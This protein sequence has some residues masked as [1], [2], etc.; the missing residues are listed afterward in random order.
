MSQARAPRQ[1]SEQHQ[2]LDAA[3]QHPKAPQPLLE[4]HHQL[5]ELLVGLQAANG[6]VAE[7]VGHRRQWERASHGRARGPQQHM[8]PALARAALALKSGQ[9]RNREAPASAGYAVPLQAASAAESSPATADLSTG[10]HAKPW[11]GARKCAH[12]HHRCSPPAKG[13]AKNKKMQRSRRKMQT[14]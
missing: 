5:W 10:H 9:A 2:P 4:V 1:P 14:R 12:H 7:Q 11:T 3:R 6:I 8:P 13:G